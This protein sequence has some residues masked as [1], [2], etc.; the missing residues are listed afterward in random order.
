[1]VRKIVKRYLP[2]IPP[3]FH[4]SHPW[5]T[6]LV[7]WCQGIPPILSPSEPKLAAPDY[8]DPQFFTFQPP[9]KLQVYRSSDCSTSGEMHACL[10]QWSCSCTDHLSVQHLERCTP[11]S[12]NEAAGIA[13]K[14]RQSF[15]T[16]C[17]WRQLAPYAGTF[18][19]NLSVR[20]SKI[21]NP[22]SVV[23][24][25]RICQALTMA[26]SGVSLVPG[27]VPGAGGI[28]VPGVRHV[29]V[30]YPTWLALEWE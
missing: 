14:R 8:G 3:A 2:K 22:I 27:G 19:L 5:V 28:V 9:M 20:Y 21:I 7:H 26:N 25:S 18:A 11:A 16:V 29:T 15:L 13:N 23:V 12:I 6:M 10:N 1:M 17:I 4:P 24:S 30:T